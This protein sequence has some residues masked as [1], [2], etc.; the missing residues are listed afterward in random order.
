MKE[1]GLSAL[2]VLILFLAFL[3]IALAA[4]GAPINL[5]FNGNA[6]PNYDNT[7]NF[8]L[9]WSEGAGD[10]S[11]D[12]KIYIYSNGV[13]FSSESNN[14]ETGYTFSNQTNANYT[15]RVEALNATGTG[16]NSTDISIVVDTIKP[17]IEFGTGVADNASAG[18]RDWIF[19]NVSASDANNESL[20]FSLYNESSL[21]FRNVTNYTENSINWTGLSDSVYTYNVSAN[22]SATNEESTESRVFYI[23]SDAPSASLS[24]ESS[25]R[26]SIKVDFSCSDFGVSGEKSCDISSDSGEVSGNEITGLSCDQ[27]YEIT[28]KAEDNAGNTVSVSETF[29]TRD[30]SESSGATSEP[31]FWQTTY[32]EDKEELRNIGEISR[33]MSEKERM[34][35]KVDGSTHH[36]GVLSI[37]SSRVTIE[38]S[39]D[40]QEESLSE[41][42]T[43]RFNLNDDGYYDVS[44]QIVSIES[45]KASVIVSSIREEVEAETAETTGLDDSESDLIEE[46]EEIE[47]EQKSNAL[48]WIVGIIILVLAAAGIV[49]YLM[50]K[51]K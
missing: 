4:P 14:S 15:F 5:T 28:V 16:V 46:T 32:V 29:S 36:I 42:E 41:G 31:L 47:D 22:D 8:T 9:N 26:S 35:I 50:R 2:A 38:V 45:D 48:R 39:S 6:T 49:F 51:N 43:G 17:D 11:V 44:V 33:N 19:V 18:K 12:Y 13:L 24:F 7:G 23:D 27:S 21:V 30:C 10:D 34:R 25:T 1:R 3:G 37:E 20:I 40:P